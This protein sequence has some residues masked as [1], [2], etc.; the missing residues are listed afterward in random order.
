MMSC[1]ELCSTEEL[2]QNYKYEAEE[3]HILCGISS[4][5]DICMVEDSLVHNSS[6]SV[7]CT[8]IYSAI[9]Y[10]IADHG[11]QFSAFFFSVMYS[12]IVQFCTVLRIHAD[13]LLC[14]SL[15]RNRLEV[16]PNDVFANNSQLTLV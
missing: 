7:L 8:P 11:R 4:R 13:H 6:S 3:S 12:Y 15:A 16:L 10:C 5:R 1:D 2:A 9:L 14:S